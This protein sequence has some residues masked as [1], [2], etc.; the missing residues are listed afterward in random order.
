MEQS[1]LGGLRDAGVASVAARTRS[2]PVLCRALE[3][4]EI[5]AASK[6]GLTLPE[7]SR[8]LNI[9]KSSAHMILVTLLREGYVNRSARTRRFSL[10]FKLFSLASEALNGLPI[11][12]AAVPHMRQLMLSTNLT[13][14]LAVLERYE[15]VLI[16]KVDPP[17]AARLST[18]IGRRMEVHCTGV[19][20][21][22]IAHLP[23][24]E[25]EHLFRTRVFARHNDNTIVSAKRM[26]AELEKVRRDGYSIDDEEDEVGLRCL[27]AP[28]LSQDGHLLGALSIAGTVIEVNNANTR[29]LVAKL[30]GAAAQIART[31]AEESPKLS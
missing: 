13:V 8:K 29:E 5:L 3:T 7:V 10:G 19:G 17:G 27:G 22:L 21:A 28:V 25:I 30:K 14:H 15:A 20:K 23:D 1:D 24:D 12:E 9:A 18:W 11:R 6:N 2:V 26:M 4:L 31:M 16:A